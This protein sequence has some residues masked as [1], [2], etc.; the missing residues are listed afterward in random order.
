MTD[1][2]CKDYLR[3]FSEYIDGELAPELCMKI[4]THLKE[5]S[6]CTIVY[7]TLRR[8]IDLVHETKGE[9]NLPGEVRERLF[10]RLSLDDF[11]NSTEV[12]D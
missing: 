2:H 3:R 8:T 4:E 1:G 5:C 12:K 7:N 9:E 6:N 11:T 10:K